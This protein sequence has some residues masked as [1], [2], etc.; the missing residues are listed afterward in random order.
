M[1]LYI[2]ARWSR[3][4]VQPPTQLPSLLSHK[5]KEVAYMLSL[6]RSVE[7]EV[8]P[9]VREHFVAELERW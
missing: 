5:E 7:P 1:L 8:T 2:D 3:D 6:L 4:M 9:N